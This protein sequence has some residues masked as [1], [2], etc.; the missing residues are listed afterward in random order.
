MLKNY[1]KTAW[2]NLWKN[3]FYSLLNILGLAIGMAVCIVIILFVQYERNFD[4]IHQKN[5]YRLDEVQKWE[6]M[7]AP[8]KVALSMYPMGP[9]LQ[10]EFPEIINFTRVNPFGK[11][12][13]QVNGIKHALAS[14]HLV[15]S[16][17]LQLFDFK[18][19]KG[20]RST[21]LQNPN[22]L[23]LTQT[24]AKAL[25]G[26]EEALGKTITTSGRDTTNFTI[27][28]IL[29]DIPENSHIQFDALFSM[30]TYVNAE[31]MQN[32]GSNWLTTYLEIE[33]NAAIRQLEK[34]FP[35]FLVDHMGQERAKGY[36][37]FLQSLRDVHAGSTDITHDY[38]NH[39]KF[40][41]KY[42]LIFFA[43]ALVVLAI[44][45]INFVNLTT[46][47]SSGRA[48]EIGVRK[49]TGAKRGQLYFQFIG[50]SIFLCLI[51]LLL[52]IGMV[53]LMLLYVNHISLRAISFPLF[54]TPGLFFSLLFGAILLGGLAGLYPAAYLSSF[55]PTIVL[56]GKASRIK[57]KAF[58]RNLLVV[59]QFACAI[60]L[61][62]STLI[63][64]KQLRF[65][66]KKDLGFTREQ[67]VTVSLDN[68][69]NK[70]YEALKQELLASNLI[71]GVTANQQKLGNNL[72]QTGV[73]YY[74]NGPVRN[75][76]VSQI[77]VDPDF[78]KVYQ[79]PLVAGRD[80]SSDRLAENGKTY[81]INESLA[82]ELL[83][84]DR[85]Q[86]IESLIG[87]RF[88]F[89]GLDSNSTIIG[90]AKDFN[91]NSLHHKIETLCLYNQKDFG[92][93]E[94]SIKINTAK[95]QD[96]L[97]YIQSVWKRVSPD[98]D[99]EYQFLDDHF[100]DL[101][102]ADQTTSEIVGI[103]A[104]LA[105]LISCMGLL[106]LATFVAEQ[107]IKEIGIRKVLGASVRGLV[108]LLS[109]D[110]LKLVL[111][112]IFIAVPVAWLAMNKW[113]EDFAY[114]INIEWWTFVLAGILAISIAMLTISFRAIKSARANP[115]KSLRTE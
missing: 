22:S 32:W 82:K 75:F 61:M 6:G 3:K 102:K 52:A 80:F 72:H 59:G 104:A 78:L 111:I 63:A 19:L 54:A 84:E 62:S 24:S 68:N 28:A 113:L 2:R 94:L 42:T 107:R 85:Q 12:T 48:K 29:A 83:K 71:K 97:A 86:P 38:I 15:D 30:N 40:N 36:E 44:A 51:A 65:M 34:R 21:A 69:A 115:V 108:Q 64:I 47:R 56:K 35:A 26:S 41:S 31:Q 60:A 23:V 67:I 7:V 10:R 112:A 81:I 53:K 14:T 105:V 58:F 90:V 1:F 99:F 92:Y 55:K 39:Q 96:A 20:D 79:I 95:A 4:A 114:R 73:N 45:S 16:T 109:K 43:I 103:L 91:F 89:G 8:Q 87:Q 5:L 9:T 88:G 37:L 76:A 57:G 50:E 106:G 13:F 49:S 77:V 74:G 18:L 93:S 101:Y 27:T 66:Q 100:E 25:F 46:A 11:V 70:K 17:F 110:F 33:L 98:S